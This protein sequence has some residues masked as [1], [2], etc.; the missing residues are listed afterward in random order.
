MHWSLRSSGMPDWQRGQRSV[1]GRWCYG[2]EATQHIE[3]VSRQA[4][5][6]M[7]AGSETRRIPD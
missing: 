4:H 5:A 2:L 1:S 3:S 7:K 6:G